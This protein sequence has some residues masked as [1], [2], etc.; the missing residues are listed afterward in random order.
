MKFLVI[1]D[2]SIDR[3]VAKL[4]LEQSFR[5]EEVKTVDSAREGIDWLSEFGE[6]QEVV[7]LLDIKMPDLSGFDFLNLYEE[8][9]DNVKNNCKIVMI[10]STIDQDEME[11]ANNHSR[12]R[13]LLEKPLNPDTLE[14][15]VH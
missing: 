6:K 4:R 8:L 9:P 2:S 7:I 14:P 15:L 13:K 12:V 3:F 5:P 1:D 10:S 11:R